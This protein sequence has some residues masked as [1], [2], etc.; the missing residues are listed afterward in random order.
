MHLINNSPNGRNINKDC[1]S[2]HLEH[3]QKAVVDSGADLGVAFDG[4]ADRALFVDEKGSIVDGDAT[5]W[6]LP[7]VSRKKAGL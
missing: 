5:L 2:L 6:I 4:D 7:D 1:G 3:L